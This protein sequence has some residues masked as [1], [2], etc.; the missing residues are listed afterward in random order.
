[1]RYWIEILHCECVEAVE[2]ADREAVD[3]LSLEVLGEPGLAEGVPAHGSMGWNQMVFQVP[4]NQPFYD[5]M[6]WAGKN[7]VASPQLLSEAYNLSNWH[8]SYHD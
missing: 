2:Q 8:I 5:F 1:M 3:A 6:I 4:S 7:S